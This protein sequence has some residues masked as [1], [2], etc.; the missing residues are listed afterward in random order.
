MSESYKFL[1]ARAKKH[2]ISH[3]T[4]TANDHSCGECYPVTTAENEIFKRFWE[5]YQEIIPE[6]IGFSS[7]TVE[8]LEGF[9]EEGEDFEAKK[10]NNN[11]KNIMKS[12]IKKLIGSIR[13]SR[14]PTYTSEQIREKVY[15]IV[16]IS[17]KFEKTV[18]ETRKLLKE[19]LGEEFHEEIEETE[20]EEEKTF[21]EEITKE[22]KIVRIK[23][24][25]N[26]PYEIEGQGAEYEIEFDENEESRVI[27]LEEF[28]KLCDGKGVN[29]ERILEEIREYVTR[30]S[31][32]KE[33]EMETTE[34]IIQEIENELGREISYIEGNILRMNL[35]KC[36]NTKKKK[37]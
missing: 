37:K 32:E 25:K 24:G 9:L 6:A 7:K 5:L 1:E 2:D 33:N 20:Q 23:C 13:Y 22:I 16:I 17:N 11:K 34:Q 3:D 15:E 26:G 10:W 35:E 4:K 21:I 30:K 36:E 27:P 29:T 28:G 18:W 19:Y 31:A 14:S 12:K 8:N